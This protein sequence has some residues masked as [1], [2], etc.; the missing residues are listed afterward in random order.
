MSTNIL[1]SLVETISQYCSLPSAEVAQLLSIPKQQSHGDIAFPCFALAKKLKKSPQQCALEMEKE[2]QL[3]EL[4]ER[5]EVVGPFVNF[6]FNKSFYA[7]EV[8][9]PILEGKQLE[10]SD[11]LDANVVID[12]SSPNIAKPFH[13]GHLRA[14]LI[15]N[16]LDRVCRNVGYTTTSINHLGDWGTQFGYVWAGCHLWGEPKN[17]E[18]ASLV[19]VYR[20]ATALKEEAAEGDKSEVA[21][22]AEQYFVDLENGKEYATEFWK[23]CVEVSLVYLEKTYRRLGISFDHYTGE[24]FYSDKLDKVKQELN[25]AELLSESRGALGVELAEP[26]GFARIYT[27][28]G[29]S[30]YLARDIAAAEYRAQEFQFSRALYVVGAPQQLHFKQLKAL[31][32][33]LNKPYADDITH[34]AFGHVLGMKTRGGGNFIELNEFLDEAI[35]RAREAYRANVS[36]RPEG[37]DEEEIAR[38]VALAAIMFSNLNRSN[39]KDVHFSWDNALTFQGDTGPYL[40]YAYARINGIVAKAPNEGMQDGDVSYDLL[41]EDSAHALIVKIAQFDEILHKTAITCEPTFLCNYSLDLAKAFSKCYQELKVVG[42]EKKLAH[43][44][45]ALFSATQR[46]L[47]KSIELLGIPILDRM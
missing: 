36:K 37:L 41:N 6:H 45:L 47:G 40:L 32:K 38:S 16:C 27:P 28:D 31:L 30:L 17:F 20:K 4:V 24:S 13:V 19:D 9:T 29:R 46:V 22:L 10:K 23:R 5:I 2:L 33:A 8:L 34:V 14:T 25:R 39:I 3:P 11:V 21:L 12:Y 42:A 43:A 44:R 7:R 1:Q 35:E 15:G 26:L 18:V